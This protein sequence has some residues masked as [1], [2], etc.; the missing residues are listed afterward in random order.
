M[1]QAQNEYSEEE[2]RTILSRFRCEGSVLK[3]AYDNNL[4]SSNL[5]VERL[6]NLKFLPPQPNDDDCFSEKEWN[7]FLHRFDSHQLLLNFLRSNCFVIDKLA[8][9]RLQEL[10]LSAS[11]Y[12][13]ARSC[14]T[15]N[16]SLIA[17]FYTDKSSLLKWAREEVGINH[18]AV[19]QRL[20]EL[21]NGMIS[22]C[23][24][25]ELLEE[26]TKSLNCEEVLTEVLNSIHSQS[27]LE[28]F[29][30]EHDLLHDA[31]FLQRKKD[32]ISSASSSSQESTSSSNYKCS[33]CDKT[34]LSSKILSDHI[35]HHIPKKRNSG[36]C[37]TT[38]KTSIQEKTTKPVSS[39][40]V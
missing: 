27:E 13:P 37:T 26:M 32:L 3:W 1:E 23:T 15:D 34:F 33:F 20:V 28:Q 16:V 6:Q 22:V 9:K 18:P 29:G 4:L 30:Q 36:S 40:L 19:L 38:N 21:E 14:F 5:V 11:R 2:I 10:K 7:E 17:S 35:K 24:N 39:F 31:V 12:K 25:E 8:Q